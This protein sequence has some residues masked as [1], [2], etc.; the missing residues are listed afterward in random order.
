MSDE[1]YRDE[2]LISAAG[3]AVEERGLFQRVLC[4]RCSQGTVYR[5]AGHL[6]PVAFCGRTERP[7][8]TDIAECTGF[9]DPRTPKL[10]E[11]QEIAL[12]IDT[13]VGVSDK[14]YA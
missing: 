3:R 1:E 2:A 13:R 4:A 5:R 6:E 8:P 7:V 11:M 12:P 9:S 14:S 10:F